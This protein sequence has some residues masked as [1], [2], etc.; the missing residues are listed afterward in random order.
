MRSRLTRGRRALARTIG[1]TTVAVVGVLAVGSAVSA[2]TTESGPDRTIGREL[3]ASVAELKLESSVAVTD[4]AGL[5]G[6]TPGAQSGKVVVRLSSESGATALANGRS[7]TAAK[8]AARAQ[9]DAF[10]AR[11]QGI[12]SGARVV[13]RTQMVLNA[14]FVEVDASKLA[15]IAKDSAVVSI[16]PV[17][18]YELDLSET[19]PYI[20]AKAVQDAKTTGK[21]IKVAVLDSGVDYTH[22]DLGGAGAAAYAANNPTIVE[23]GTFPTAKVKGGY[24]FVGSTWPNTA[25][26]PDPDPLDDGALTGGVGTGHGTHVADIIGGKKGVAPGVDV[27]AVKVCS[28]VS[29]SCSGIALIQ[30]MEWTLDPNGDGKLDDRMHIINMSLGSSYGQPFDDDLS[31]AVENATKVGILTVA[32]AGNSADKPYAAGT[33]SSTDA[34]LSVAQTAVPSAVLALMQI[35][36]PGTPTSVPA[37]FQPW[38]VPLTTLIEGPVQYG[39]GAGGNLNGCAA[40]APGSL[41][42]KIVLVDR[43]ACNFTLKIVNIDAAG[44]V[45]G[46]IGQ[47]APGDAFEGGDGGDR[48]AGFRHRL[49]ADHPFRNADAN[50]SRGGAFAAVRHS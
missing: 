3:P 45:L 16:N 2:Q 4:G 48:P 30:G 12:D 18:Q 37:V 50:R 10:I 49:R 42:G 20:G 24:D 25:E 7:E 5:L 40:F 31:L 46:I 34:A 8:A 43:G 39:D 28:T 21:G 9:Q 35:L 6:Q 32:S 44:G 15:D 11:V 22:T 33:P 38:S 41:T 19:V 47:N 14:V 27:Y 1:L 17:G 13:A 26:T 23:P 36:A 29:T